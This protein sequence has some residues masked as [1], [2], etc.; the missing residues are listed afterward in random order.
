M[1]GEQPA[2]DLMLPALALESARGRQTWALAPTIREG[3]G[4]RVIKTAVRAPNMNPVGERF[5]GSLRRE[6][7]DHVLLLDDQHLENVAR[8]Y[9]RHFNRVR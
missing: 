5:V 8:Q 6:A 1:K 3:V 2:A 4:T 7:L 9:V